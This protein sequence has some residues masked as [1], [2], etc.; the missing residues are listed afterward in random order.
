MKL[1][2]KFLE[3]GAKPVQYAVHRLLQEVEIKKQHIPQLIA[4]FPGSRSECVA[5]CVP[6]IQLS[7][8][9]EY[10]AQ[11]LSDIPTYINYTPLQQ[12]LHWISNVLKSAILYKND[13]NYISSLL[14]SWN[15]VVAQKTL[16]VLS[17]DG[18]G[19]RT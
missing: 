13:L 9:T 17:S 5:Q 2:F 8:Q 12:L 3:I 4:V 16:I 11:H 19:N 10:S 15:D 14:K 18:N 1:V 7:V 6:S